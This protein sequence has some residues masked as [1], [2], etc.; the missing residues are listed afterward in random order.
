MAGVDF[1]AL[2]KDLT[3]YSEAVSKGVRATAFG[4]IAAIWAVFSAEGIKLLANGLL[5]VPTGM[6][7]RLAFIFASAALI[8]DVLQYISAL[9]MTNIGMDRWEK[10]ESAGEKVEFYY[11]RDNL[12]WFGMALY[13]L[14]Y[15]LFPTKL[16]LAVAGG[17]TFFFF[18]FAINVA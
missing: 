10:R 2:Q 12:G 13:W 6:L 9:W 3:W 17:L 8:V 16:I 18:A 14:N 11:N 5:G 15:G 1:K 4:I 7:V